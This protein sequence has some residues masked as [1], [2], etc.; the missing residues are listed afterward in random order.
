MYF[1]KASGSTTAEQVGVLV[2]DARIYIWQ[3]AS[4]YQTV[5]GLHSFPF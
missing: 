4:V 5:S 3:F 1:Q 2:A